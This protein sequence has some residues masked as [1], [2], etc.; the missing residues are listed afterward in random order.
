V[1][2]AVGCQQHEEVPE[3]AGEN[4]QRIVTAEVGGASQQAQE[5]GLV[6]PDCMGPLLEQI[7]G[8]GGSPDHRS[9]A[10]RLAHAD[11]AWDRAGA[12]AARGQRLSFAKKL[13]RRS[14]LLTYFFISEATPAA[15]A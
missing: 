9:P 7:V 2:K 3:E 1:Q 13:P 14:R 8:L 10:C 11:G 15:S 6:F 12:P 4:Q 5:D